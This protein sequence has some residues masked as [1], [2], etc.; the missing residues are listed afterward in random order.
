MRDQTS[1]ADG[2]VG[3]TTKRG[4]PLQNKR[5]KTVLLKL[6]EAKKVLLSAAHATTAPVGVFETVVQ[7]ILLARYYPL[8]CSC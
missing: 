1:V 6:S 7:F 3:P 5:S 2:S 8:F 4:R